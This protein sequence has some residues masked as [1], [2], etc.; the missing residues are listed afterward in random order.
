MELNG[1]ADSNK[2]GP[3]SL[4]KLRAFDIRFVNLRQ[5]HEISS[6]TRK[7]SVK[8][9]EVVLPQVHAGIITKGDTLASGNLEIF[10]DPNFVLADS[11]SL[12]TGSK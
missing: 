4:P 6:P 9:F 2:K 8:E 7:V 10:R 12:L 11:M 5:L 1:R 3:E